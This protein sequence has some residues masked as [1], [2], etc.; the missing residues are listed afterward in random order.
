[1]IEMT[2]QKKRNLG[3]L[4]I[5]PMVVFI[6]TFIYESQMMGKLLLV[7]DHHSAMTIISEYY[8]TLAFRYGIASLLT[9]AV[10]LYFM[11]H[12]ARLKTMRSSAKIL[13]IVVLA[14]FMPVSFPLFW[15]MEINK[16]PKILDT[17]EDIA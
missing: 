13:W 2:K 6:A 12:V 14:A 10:L 17:K 7:G 3:I 9:V 16:E 5:L 15:F 8:A 11:Y 1:M 4:S